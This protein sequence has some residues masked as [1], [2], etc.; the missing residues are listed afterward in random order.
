MR[1]YSAFDIIGPAMIGPSS[2]HTAGAARL[3]K[4]A[5]LVA[6]DEIKG[7]KFLLHGSFA[8]T[9]RGHG[10]DRA[11]VAG[12]LGMDPWDESL[13]DSLEIAEKQGLGVTFL[14][15]DLGD[16]HPNTVK[17]I[18]EKRNGSS[19]E[20]IGSSIGGGNISITEIDGEPL[21]F[22]GAYPTLIV[23]HVDVPGMVSNVTSVM[24]REG[25]NI[26]F[27]KVYRSSKGEMATMIFE[28]DH[29]VPEDVVNE[30]SKLAHINSVR[31]I[32][33]IKEA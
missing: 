3:G 31:V 23:K 25:I 22:T 6:G 12:I 5:K 18:I 1:K 2:S 29:L 14:E 16:V 10:T 19:I 30:I 11:L 17:F 27:M 28:T 15:A 24:S 7:V 9:Y 21:E 26:A 33:P 4:V 32:S 20:I 8:K 13:R